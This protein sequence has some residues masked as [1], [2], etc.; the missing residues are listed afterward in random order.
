MD[1]E[2]KA[3]IATSMMKIE[4]SLVEVL[5]DQIRS[6]YMGSGIEARE[7]GDC[8]IALKSLHSQ[9]EAYLRDV[10]REEES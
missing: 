6:G 10:E 8:F 7:L 5:Y 3:L 2:K 4:E 1:M 9:I